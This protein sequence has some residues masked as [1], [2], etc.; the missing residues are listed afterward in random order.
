[1]TAKAMR[2]LQ[3]QL[4]SSGCGCDRCRCRCRCRRIGIHSPAPRRTTVDPKGGAQD[5]RRFPKG[6][7]CPV[8]KSRRNHRTRTGGVVWASPS[9][10]LLLTEGN[11]GGLLGQQEKVTRLAQR[12]ESFDPKNRNL[13]R[14]RISR[15][16]LTPL[17]QN[18]ETHLQPNLRWQA[19]F[20]VA[21]HAAPTPKR[22]NSA[23][24]GPAIAAYAAP[25][26]A[27]TDRKRN[28]HRQA[29]FAVAAYAAPTPKPKAGAGAGR[30]LIR[31]RTPRN[32]HHASIT[33]PASASSHRHPPPP[34][35]ASPPVQVQQAPGLARAPQQA[36]PAQAWPAWV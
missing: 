14:N 16:R 24:D 1:M 4:R 28:R 27:G 30:K 6:Q 20:A 3:W 25:T 34:A 31:G 18:A 17:P 8:E 35:S 26:E 5:A 13:R 36:Q 29:K 23:A 7:G 12:A 11:P 32:S 19:K 22:A 33:P 2:L 21:T 15:S 10:W 9:L